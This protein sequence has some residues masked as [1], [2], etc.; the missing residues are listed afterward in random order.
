QES[1]W[2]GKEITETA[3]IINEAKTLA[4]QDVENHFLRNENLFYQYFRVR[5]KQFEIL[6]RMLKIVS[7]ISLTVEQNKMIANY[8]NEVSEHIHPGNTAIIYLEKLYRLKVEFCNME[9]PKTR[10]EFEARA[11][12]LQFIN[13]M[14]QYL[15]IKSSF[16]GLDKI[17][18]K[19]RHKAKQWKTN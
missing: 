16:R 14:E 1:S 11:S 7:S 2:G 12:L 13:E 18:K 3:D 17:I 15:H 4:F 10:E 5:E 6:E 19:S 8:I 9:L